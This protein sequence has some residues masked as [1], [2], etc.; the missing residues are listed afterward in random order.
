MRSGLRN[1]NASPMRLHIEAMGDYIIINDAYNASPMSMLAAIDTLAEVAKGRTVAVLGDMLEL[2]DIGVEA[3]RQIGEK[4]AQYK[5]DIVVTVGVLAG[6]I[7]EAASEHG[8]YSAVACCSHD[9][10]TETLKRIIKPGDTI[11]IK[12][13]RGM[14]MENIVKM[15]L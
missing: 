5:I 12:G 2:G 7:A 8:I 14:K 3:H 11:L 13:S 10:A 4:L 1:F 15:F 6:N 9:E